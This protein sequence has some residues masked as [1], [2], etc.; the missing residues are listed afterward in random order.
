MKKNMH[1]VSKIKKALAYGAARGMGAFRA[2]PKKKNAPLH[3]NPE[4][5]E[6]K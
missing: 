5:Q 6:E 2:R 1:N 4:K 3:E